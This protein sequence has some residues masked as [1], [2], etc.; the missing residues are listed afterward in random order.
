[1]KLAISSSGKDLNSQ[2][3]PRFGRCA[4]F[5][6][7][8]PDDMS[9]EV[10]NNDSAVLGG[11]AGIQSAQFV[12]SKGV[13]AV[14]T[15]NC[16]PNAVQT[17]TAAGVELFAGQT[18]TVKEVVERFKKG[19][20]RPTSEANVDSH[21]GMAPGAGSGPGGGMG[22]GRG[23]GGGMGGG[24]GMGR[25]MGGGRGMGQGM[26]G[27]RA[28]GGGAGL[29]GESTSIKKGSGSVSNDSE[30]ETLKKKADEINKQLE[31]IITRINQLETKD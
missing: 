29:S 1:M 23:M 21:F 14:I 18:G 27:G 26:G 9:F 3:D 13:D 19:Q 25:G 2:L 7:I 17:L 22:G 15:G 28:I 6:V 30:L 5:L 16:G 20:L 24:R 8:N 4:Y 31:G 11:G 12:A 10:F